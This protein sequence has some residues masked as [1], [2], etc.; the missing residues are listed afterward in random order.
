M[1][2]P[3][4]IA[5]NTWTGGLQQ[6]REIPVPVDRSRA[7]RQRS[8]PHY[9]ADEDFNIF[10]QQDKFSP[11]APSP[12]YLGLSEGDENSIHADQLMHDAQLIQSTSTTHAHIKGVPST[13]TG[14][15]Q[16]D[17]LRPPP[18]KRTR[19]VTE[20]GKKLYV[21]NRRKRACRN[22]KIAKCRVRLTLLTITTS[23]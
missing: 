1:P 17:T 4:D 11:S 20:E 16:L 10:T 18:N 21:E 23:N 14:C 7:Q 13:H 2:S 5:P 8:A 6:A 9:T 19:V 12:S 22:C 15:F 3:V